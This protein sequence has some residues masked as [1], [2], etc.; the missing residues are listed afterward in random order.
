[1]SEAEARP[2]PTPDRDSEPFWQALREGEL[3]LQR[4]SECSALRWPPRALCNRCRSFAASWQVLSGRGRLVSWVRTHQVFAP[5]Y[6]SE[7]PYCTVQVAPEEQDDI[8]LIG[9][10]QGPADPIVGQPVKARFVNADAGF[11]LVDWEPAGR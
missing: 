7:V 10:W 2:L 9:G 11:V 3:R 8:L 4:C 5:V 6:R 1:M